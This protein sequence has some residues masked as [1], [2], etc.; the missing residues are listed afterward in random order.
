MNSCFFFGAIYILGILN[1]NL[2]IIILKLNLIN[3]SLMHLK[4]NFFTHARFC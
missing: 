1:F 3:E 4:N 2:K